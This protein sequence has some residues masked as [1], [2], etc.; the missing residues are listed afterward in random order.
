MARRGQKGK[1]RNLAA[2]QRDIDA[3]AAN[4]VTESPQ[5]SRSAIQ[6]DSPIV[7]C[8]ISSHWDTPG[9]LVQVLIARETA[10]GKLVAGVA[11]V[12]LGCLGAKNGFA[13]RYGSYSRFQ[14]ELLSP[15]MATDEMIRA[16]IDL[17]A[18]IVREGIAYARSLGFEPHR[19]LAQFEPL[20]AGADPDAAPET[21]PLGV[22][23]KPFYVNGPH[24]NVRHIINT[25]ERTVGSGNYEYIVGFPEEDGPRGLRF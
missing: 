7:D 24:D 15:I 3:R 22:D 21:V 5:P 10:G 12:D 1:P 8:L 20:L 2:L 17:A 4:V 6:E 11:L 25:L 23:G 13:R 14:V 9:N 19:D 18:K 16:D